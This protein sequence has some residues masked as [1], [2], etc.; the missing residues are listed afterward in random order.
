MSLE[1]SDSPPAGCGI[2]V[3]AKASRA[4]L[5]KTRLA[6]SIGL[7]EAAR[8]NTAF[9]RD[10]ADN[11]VAASGLAA[12]R[13]VAL[14]GYMAYGPPGESSFFDF[15]P[16]D[17]GLVEAWRDTFGDT[18]AQAFAGVL[19][20]GHASACLLNADSPTLPPTSNVDSGKRTTPERRVATSS[21]PCSPGRDFLASLSL[22]VPVLFCRLS[23][24]RLV[25]LLLLLLLPL[26]YPI[27]ILSA[28]VLFCADC[29]RSSS[30][31]SPRKHHNS[32]SIA[33]V[34]AP[35]SNGLAALGSTTRAEVR[36]LAYFPPPHHGQQPKRSCRLRPEKCA[37]AASAIDSRV[38]A[39]NRV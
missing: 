25:R 35:V 34:H 23:A 16:E 31:S 18:L 9:L 21:V 10:A 12:A 5:T 28:S 37:R 19:R 20:R 36:P 15:R 29:R 11:L 1:A 32:I 13:G 33:T 14:A 38:P 30:R 26:F 27:P 8:L 22:P 24:L 6:P 3:M 2:A 39:A 4:G 17:I 7:Y